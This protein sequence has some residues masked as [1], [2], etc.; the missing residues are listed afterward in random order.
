MS[1][2]EQLQL[3]LATALTNCQI[4]EDNE[5]KALAKLE[6]IES[7]PDKWR[8][9]MKHHNGTDVGIGGDAAFN[10]CANE[11]D[12]KLENDNA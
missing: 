2:I 12:T 1:Q 9:H 10:T 4:H 11:L 8:E 5:R 3:R 7:L 6:R